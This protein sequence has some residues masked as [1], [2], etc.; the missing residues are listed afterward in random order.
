MHP[1]PSATTARRT[2]RGA[3]ATTSILRWTSRSTL[4]AGREVSDRVDSSKEAKMRETNGREARMREISGKHNSKPTSNK[5]INSQHT[6]NK[7]RPHTNNSKSSGRGCKQKS[8]K[9][10]R[11]SSRSPRLPLV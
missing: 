10:T 9:E 4:W 3:A 5:H 1:V 11:G 6:N 7:P 2:S 8:S